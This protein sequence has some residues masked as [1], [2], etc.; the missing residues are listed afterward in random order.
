MIDSRE[1]KT[2][3]YFHEISIEFPLCFV[4]RTINTLA[5]NF[6]SQ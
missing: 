5:K 1:Y 3:N 6:I 2:T 4:L